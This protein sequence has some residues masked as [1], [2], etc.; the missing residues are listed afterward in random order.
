MKCLVALLVGFA[1]P[2]AG[3]IPTMAA[4]DD[5]PLVSFDACESYAVEQNN[6]RCFGEIAGRTGEWGKAIERLESLTAKQPD[7]PLVWWALGFVRQRG[8][9]MDE[10]EAA[11]RRAADLFAAEGNPGEVSLLMYLYGLLIDEG[12]TEAALEVVARG[13]AAARR[14]GDPLLIAHAAVTR[15]SAALLLFR[16]GEAERRL[17]EVEDWIESAAP[18]WLQSQWL[19]NIG[20]LRWAQGEEAATR[21][22]HQRSAALNHQQGNFFQEA[23]DRYA[24]ALLSL[25]AGDEGET[26]RALFEDVLAL[27]RRTGNRFVEGSSLVRLGVIADDGERARPLI[28]KGMKLLRAAGSLQGMFESG[29]ALAD[30]LATAEPKNVEEALALFDELYEE[31]SRRG[32]YRDMATLLYHKSFHLWELARKFPA[33]P[34]W[35]ESALAASWRSLDDA[36]LVRDLQLDTLA[37]A[38]TFQASVD[39]FGIFVGQLL[40][41]ET[42]GAAD[43]IAMAFQV[44][45]RMRARVLLD[46]LDAAGARSSGEGEVAEQRA[47]VLRGIAAV[48]RQLLRMD[49]PPDDRRRQ[50][51]RL[52][53]L[54]L[55]EKSLRARLAGADPVVALVRDPQFATLREVQ[56]TLRND[57]ALLS[58][59]ISDRT[60]PQGFFK[61]GSWLLAVTSRGA[62]AYRLPD[63]TDL[64]PALEMYRSVLV[65][66]GSAPVE[67]AVRLYQDLLGPAL[68]DLPRHVRRLI[69]VPDGALHGLPFGTLRRTSGGPPLALEFEIS[70]APSATLWRRWRRQS[71]P[72]SS[73][74]ALALVDPQWAESSTPPETAALR[75]WALAST[76]KLGR[77]PFALQEGRSLVRRLG[78]DSRLLAGPEAS[79]ARLK[80]A[81]LTRF[82]IVHFA[83][84]ALIDYDRPERSGVLL[85]PGDPAEDGLLQMR[86]I[87]DLD[88]RGRT[89]ILSACQS[90]TG[91]VIPG[92]GVMGLAQAFFVG[93]ARTVVGSLWPLQDSEAAVFFEAFY[94]H[95]AR[96]VSTGTALAAAQ[97]ER[98]EAGA[99][100]SSWAG[101]ILMGDRSLVLF[102]DGRPTPWPSLWIGGGVLLAVLAMLIFLARRR[103]S[104]GG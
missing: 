68:N 25:S 102:P 36:E 79:E 28:R 92:E 73:T 78:G 13:E 82:A 11:Y 18:A 55:Q 87:V 54:E 101:I 40:R 81:D 56:E 21:D 47:G 33:E 76:M 67:G 26:T 89:V 90:A 44:L 61:G 71:R 37:R 72:G 70:V 100:D 99:A 98:I 3:A 19:K 43:D 29:L 66:V 38:R 24:L 65:D 14:S 12:R 51:N 86:E 77:L 15:A 60:G 80:T 50:L 5:G 30:H 97:R 94:R 8:G 7:N 48:Q 58:F 75:Q 103:F 32:Q 69:V 6:Y 42:G 84:H 17:L 83:A 45:E 85:A 34:G 57:E 63:R 96:G 88:L 4:G 62:G 27:A 93:G 91:K 9:V 59:L 74:P 23:S 10:A 1:L 64:D 52:R 16:Y 31:A 46:E 35:R 20:L 41:Q 53:R 22:I 104:P 49:L 95:L 39:F 2:A